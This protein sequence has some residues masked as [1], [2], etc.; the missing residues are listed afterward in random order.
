MIAMQYMFTGIFMGLSVR[1]PHAAGLPRAR[2]PG[3]RA[4]LPR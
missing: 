4:R 1:V 2:G 3:L